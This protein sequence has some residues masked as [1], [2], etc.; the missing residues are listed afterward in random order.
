MY[1]MTFDDFKRKLAAKPDYPVRAEAIASCIQFTPLFEQWYPEFMK[2]DSDIH[3]TIEPD[4]KTFTFY[5]LVAREIPA[6]KEK[7]EG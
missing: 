5:R 4:G 2:P 6:D 7:A 3:I 1:A